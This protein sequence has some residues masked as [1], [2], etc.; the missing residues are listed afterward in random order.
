[1][2]R[3]HGHF[4]RTG[5]RRGNYLAATMIA[6]VVSACTGGG[7]GRSDDF[8]RKELSGQLVVN[9]HFNQNLIGAWRV[10]G[11][12]TLLEISRNSIAQFEEAKTSCYPDP[13]KPEG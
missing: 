4:G 13:G 6:A 7:L 9:G 10:L 12:G 3:R 5:F 2:A 1:M 11:H 8:G